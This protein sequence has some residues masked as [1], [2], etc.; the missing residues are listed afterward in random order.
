MQHTVKHND[1][2]EQTRIIENIQNISNCMKINAFAG[3]GKTSTLIR[4]AE[5]YPNR[6]FLYLA[7]N[8]AVAEEAKKRFPNNVEAKTTHSLAYRKI[9]QRGES[10]RGDYKIKEIGDILHLDFISA[11]IV[12]KMFLGFCNSSYY[13]IDELGEELV[14]SGERNPFTYI[15]HAERLYEMMRRRELTI[16]YS[17]MLKEFQLLQCAKYYNF[18]YVMLDEGQDTNPVTFDIFN[19]FSG[20]KIIVGDTH[21][22][23][24]AF[25][26][27][28]DA[29]ESV[30]A[31][32]NL[33]LTHTFRCKPH[34]ADMANSVL[35]KYKAETT[36]IVSVASGPESNETTAYISRANASLIDLIN[37]FD[38]FNLTRNPVEIFKSSLSVL[39]YKRRQPD[40]IY[41]EYKFL[42]SFDSVIEFESYLEE[43]ED[44]E[45][46]VANQMVEN[47]QD[48]LEDLFLKA[49]RCNSERSNITLTTAHS[50]KGLEYDKVVLLQD[51]P[52]L[53]DIRMSEN[54]SEIQK[55]N[56]Y[57]LFYVAITRAR[58]SLVNMTEN[59]LP[60][61][62]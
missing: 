59:Q 30:N 18:D 57:N 62:K 12:N 21:Q 10:L 19:S 43:T 58:H 56:E 14:A 53:E 5:E 39:Y 44:V 7:F 22:Q 32:I 24:Y 31:D 47:Y 29:M 2:K 8:K 38:S 41:A 27:S 3:A 54:F 49:D 45:L 6:K 23:V 15:R 20:R 16:T 42:K 34:I 51:F 52:N 61:D 11:A 60:G 1:T 25:R 37:D 33:K 46:N 35:S 17:F 36:Q 4:I 9:V 26:G 50:S 13:N 48:K 40:R 55:K 28:I